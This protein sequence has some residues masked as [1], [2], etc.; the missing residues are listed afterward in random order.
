M[1][2]YSI[3]LKAS[4]RKDLRGIPK[5]DVQRILARIESLADEPRP[6]GAEMLT[7]DDKYRVRQGDYRI[8]YRIEDDRL[9]VCVVRI[10]HRR[11]VYRG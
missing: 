2:R 9:M 10:G 5:K 1:A 7:G 6:R 11:E 3:V 4:V 8:L